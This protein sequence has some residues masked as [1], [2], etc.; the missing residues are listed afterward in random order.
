MVIAM[1]G[2]VRERA[3][4]LRG[5]YAALGR[6]MR[7]ET[8]EDRLRIQKEVYMMRLHPDLA[9][10]LPFEYDM[11]IR[12][13]YSP[14][15]AD[16]YYEEAPPASVELADRAASYAREVLGMDP[17][18]L[19]L[20]ATLAAICDYNEGF[21][22]FTAEEGLEILRE[23]RPRATEEGARRALE[24]L[25]G[26]ASRYPELRLPRPCA[27]RRSALKWA[28]KGLLN[29]ASMG[30]GGLDPLADHT[31]RAGVDRGR[32]D[33]GD[34]RAARPR[35]GDAEH[36]V[37]LPRGRYHGL[38]QG[39]TGDRGC[40]DR[41][42]RARDRLRDRWC[43]MRRPVRL[44]AF[45]S[46][47]RASGREHVSYGVILPKDFVRELGWREGD[48]LVAEWHEG[49]LRITLWREE[50]NNKLEEERRD[51]HGCAR[52]APA[53]APA[54]SCGRARNTN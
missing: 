52:P 13:P 11:F 45:R 40:R 34:R 49:D 31:L 12:G 42:R 7:T 32:A 18:I 4:A 39:H 16:A 41:L 51:G 9:P 50:G 35:R 54:R 47:D 2:E 15:L 29:G 24:V 14:E 21:P 1:L 37:V 19:E 30:C 3:A 26:L 46:R 6:E 20:A 33:P 23:R 27:P 5:I 8:F 38:H 17:W 48:A 53:Q 36:E 28:L 10:L 44:M 43:G 25:R 22:G